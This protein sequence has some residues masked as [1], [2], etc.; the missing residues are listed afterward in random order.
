MHVMNRS[1][2]RAGKDG[3]TEWFINGPLLTP[4]SAESIL[5]AAPRVP[6]QMDLAGRNT[7]PVGVKPY[8][9]SRLEGARG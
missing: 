3:S 1:F 4:W 2:S 7:V 6:K 8:S 9:R 5:L